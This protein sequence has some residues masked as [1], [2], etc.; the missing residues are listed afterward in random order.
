MRSTWGAQASAWWWGGACTG[1]G[2]VIAQESAKKEEKDERELIRWI[3][4]FAAQICRGTAK[5]MLLEGKAR[6]T[7]S[8]STCRW[9]S[10]SRVG[11]L[12]LV[13]RVINA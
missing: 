1:E 9:K 10:S 7:A 5:E 13:A 6:L 2:K 4:T 12:H 11:T 8:K 3:L